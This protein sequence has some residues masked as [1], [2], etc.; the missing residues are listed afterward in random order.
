M[1]THVVLAIAVFCFMSATTL[2][3]AEA[4]GDSFTVLKAQGDVTSKTPDAE[5]FTPATEG[6]A[7]PYGTQLKTER[8]AS[9]VLQLGENNVVRMLARSEITIHKDTKHRKLVRIQL[10]AG[11]IGVQ[12]DN[13]P[14]DVDFQVD[15]PLGVCGAVGTR[16]A[17]TYRPFHDGVSHYRK[18]EVEEGAL[19]LGG[20]YVQTDGD[21][22]REGSIFEMEAILCRER[23]YAFFPLIAVQGQDLEISLGNNNSL[24]LEDGAS[25]QVAM[26]NVPGDAPYV[27]VRVLSGRVLVSGEVMDVNTPARFIRG[28]FIMEDYN[29]EDYMNAA[30]WLCRECNR[31]LEPGEPLSDEVLQQLQ[32]LPAPEGPQVGTRVR[33]LTPVPVLEDVPQSGAE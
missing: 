11:E 8:N 10:D 7:Y 33:P 25:I 4:F 6:Q 24:I 9:A 19:N 23:K 30:E 18:I 27:A 29:A 15:T 22:L 28:R 16:F 32:Q 31:I 1:K 2:Q 17:V 14:E 21:T 5:A 12:L 13:R 26:A 20:P 3:A